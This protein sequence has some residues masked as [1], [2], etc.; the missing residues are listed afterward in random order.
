M[1]FLQDI[2]GFDPTP[3]FNLGVDKSLTNAIKKQNSAS[4]DEQNRLIQESINAQPQSQQSGAYTGGSSGGSGGGG[5]ISAGDAAAY[6]QQEGVLRA[7][8]GDIDASQNQGLAQLSDKYV[9]LENKANQ[10][11]SRALSGYATQRE[12][13]DRGKLQSYNKVDTNARTLNDS[14]RKLLGLA[15]GAGSSAYQLAAPNAVARDASGKRQAVTETFGT[16][17]RNIDTAEKDTTIDYQRY[18]SGLQSSKKSEEASFLGDIGAQ[19]ND[20]SQ[21]LAQLAADRGGAKAA[22][23][24]IN[25]INARKAELRGLFDKYRTPVN[26][27]PVKVATANLGDFTVDRTAVNASNA[28]GAQDYSP[29]EYFLKKDLQEEPIA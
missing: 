10:D 7:L 6:A 13:N 22:Q 9:G 24:Y 21:K 15:S 27:D 4:K 28:G 5:G 26:I 1:G 17:A 11:Q 25:D 18:L 2:L 14:V 19:R 8:F 23:P 29:Y 12:D 16:N 20:V 3:G